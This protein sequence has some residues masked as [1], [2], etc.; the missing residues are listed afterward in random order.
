MAEQ[1][2]SSAV[3]LLP[4][5][6]VDDI[7]PPTFAG[8]ATLLALSSGAL[9]AGWA[10]GTDAGGGVKYRIYIA[11]GSVSAAS[12]FN[13]NNLV[14]IAPVGSTY[15]PIFT[16]APANWPSPSSPIYLLKGQV[17]TVGVRAEDGAGNVETNVV[18]MTATALA[19]VDL[20]AVLQTEIED[21]ATEIAK[22]KAH[23]APDMAGVIQKQVPPVLD[24]EIDGSGQLDGTIRGS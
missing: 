11:L 19:T 5:A 21:L 12:L 17:Y 7:T 10:L 20:P 6:C 13:A 1:Y 2:S 22:I 16:L 15:R 24:G 23:I 8:I 4:N 14:E 3:Q 18:V 9:L